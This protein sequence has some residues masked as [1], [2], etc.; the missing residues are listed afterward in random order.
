MIIV[1]VIEGNIMG[2]TESNSKACWVWGGDNVYIN[3]GSD[4]IGDGSD[5]GNADDNNDDGN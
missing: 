3:K 2:I 4:V 5:G 1:V